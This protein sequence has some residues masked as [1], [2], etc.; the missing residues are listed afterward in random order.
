MRLRQRLNTE[1]KAV[2]TQQRTTLIQSAQS[3]KPLLP[4]DYKWQESP[5]IYRLMTLAAT[6]RC[7]ESR[8]AEGSSIK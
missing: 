1:E 7:S 4:R 6:R 5:N 2:I 3:Q 8:Y